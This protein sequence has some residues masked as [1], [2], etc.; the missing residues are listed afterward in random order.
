MKLPK[1]TNQNVQSVGR[2]NTGAVAKLASAKAAKG[3]ANQKAFNLLA[4]VGSDFIARKQDAEYNDALAS[5]QVNMNEFQA[6]HGAKEFYTADELGDISEDLIP[7]TVTGFEDGVQTTTIRNAIPAYEVYPH[8]LR[9][10]LEGQIDATAN[11]ISNPR[12]RNEF[13]DKAD[14]NASTMMM[15]SMIAA[16]TAQKEYTLKVGLSNGD[17]AYKRGDREMGAFQYNELDISELEKEDLI[18]EGEINAEIFD[19]TTVLRSSDPETVLEWRNLLQ[20]PSYNSL[21]EDQRVPYIKSLNTR[22]VQLGAEAKA[23]YAEAQAIQLAKYK[24][25]IDEG[26]V[27]YADIEAGHQLFLDGIQSEL[28]LSGPVSSALHS[29]LESERKE[30]QK[31]SRWQAGEVRRQEAELRRQDAE[32]RRIAGQYRDYDRQVEAAAAD[33]EKAKDEE[34]QRLQEINYSNA[35]LAVD[36]GD[37]DA[38]GIETLFDF[39]EA[40]IPHEN[41][42]SGPERTALRGRLASVNSAKRIKTNLV[43]LGANVIKNGGDRYDPDH[44]KAVDAFVEDNNITD[45]GAMFDILKDS[46]IMPQ[47]LENFFN[48]TALREDSE[49]AEDALMY[50]GNLMATNRFL[51]SEMGA[52]VK[53]IYGE[54]HV[55]VNSGLGAQKAL[56]IARDNSQLPQPQ[57][58]QRRLEYREFDAIKDNAKALRTSMKNDETVFGFKTEWFGLSYTKAISEMTGEY[59]S[60]VETFYI[61]TG[62]QDTAQKM[63]WNTLSETWGPSATGIHVT[64]DEVIHDEQRPMKYPPERMM[65]ISSNTS[66]NRLS[67]FAEVHGLDVKSMKVMNDSI[68]AIDVGGEKGPSWAI[69]MVDAETGEYYRP[70]NAATGQPLRWYG[71]HWAEQGIKWGRD[72]ANAAAIAGRRRGS[73]LQDTNK[74]F[75]S[76][77][78]TP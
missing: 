37:L 66:Q 23:A 12:M 39:T 68:T 25:G 3:N 14:V 32:S 54:A 19:V 6:R 49:F 69:M 35:Q 24:K 45:I 40:N 57:R 60:L 17:S 42:I 56:S 58:E 29:L 48:V 31:E 36:E 15:N 38:E 8:L 59:N 76:R 28:A 43:A 64:G 67:A 27:D 5:M 7:R 55:M 33:E 21:P 53:E 4:E 2:H 50:Y 41:A 47:P 1:I 46:G 52:E 70:V 26:T 11:K 62:N 74:G 65:M 10:Q 22:M 51:V 71:T 78:G 34:L 44:Q 20:D 77:A 9:Q 73:A 72:E 16:E 30:N 75:A 18:R 61:R 63:A 13:M